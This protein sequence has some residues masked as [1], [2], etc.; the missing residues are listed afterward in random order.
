VKNISN[1]YAMTKK[2]ID[3]LKL[4]RVDNKTWIEVPDNIPDSVAIKRFNER[5]GLNEPLNWK[6]KFNTLTHERN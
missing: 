6:I 5:Q 4:V 2:K 3:K 1:H